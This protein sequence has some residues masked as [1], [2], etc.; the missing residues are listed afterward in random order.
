M[1][2]ASEDDVIDALERLASEGC[3]AA[4]AGDLPALEEGLHRRRVLLARIEETLSLARETTTT[5]EIARRLEKV[6]E[7]DR[8]AERHLAQAREELE[9]RVAS[10]TRGEIG[11]GAYAAGGS[12][13]GKRVDER[14]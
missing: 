3:R 4:Q 6:L 13:R 11:L 7:I 12:A 8:E 2:P 10:M 5:D 1:K 9:A 14:R